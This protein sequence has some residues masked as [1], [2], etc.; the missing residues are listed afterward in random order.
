[1][2]SFTTYA[3]AAMDMSYGTSSAD[4]SDDHPTFH[5]ILCTVA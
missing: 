5:K 2:D 1:M 4:Q 3:A